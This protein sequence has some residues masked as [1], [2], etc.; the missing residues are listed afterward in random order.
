MVHAC[1][2]PRIYHHSW[3]PGDAVI[4]DNRCLL[5][6]ACPWDLAVPRLMFHAR[7]AGDEI[8]EFAANA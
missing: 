7:I 2:A 6:Q 3:T 8:S 1:Q 5:H 4:W